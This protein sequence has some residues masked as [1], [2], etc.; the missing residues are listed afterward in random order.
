MSLWSRLWL[1]WRLKKELFPLVVDWWERGKSRLKALTISY[2][3]ERAASRRARRDVLTRLID[4]LKCQVDG[5]VA[6]CLGLYRSA[7]AELERLDCAEAKGSRVRA[8]IRCIEEGEA[9]TAFFFRKERKQSADRWIPALRDSDGGVHSDVEGIGA[10]LSNFYSLLFS[11]ECCDP[12]G[13]D[14]LFFLSVFV[15]ASRTRV[16]M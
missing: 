5:S 14:D 7:L 4:H 10:V 11:E 13:Q 3:K 15:L 9:S 16:V 2:C 1:H 12:S 8:R 6:S